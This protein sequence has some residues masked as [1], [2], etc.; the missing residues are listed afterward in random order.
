MNVKLV[1]II[2]SI[3]VWTMMVHFIVSVTLDLDWTIQQM[4]LVMVGSLIWNEC[5]SFIPFKTLMNVV[6]EVLAVVTY[7]LMLLVATPA[8]VRVD[9][10]WA[11]T[12]TLV[13]ILMSVLI[14]MEDVNTFA[15]TLM[16]AIHARA[17]Q[18]TN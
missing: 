18:G 1:Q 13:L 6:K 8:V 12:I 17:W 16:A 10:S 11:V 15:R 7:V 3:H 14:I 4:P 5:Y 9:M 2:V